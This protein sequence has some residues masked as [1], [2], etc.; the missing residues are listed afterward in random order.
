[1]PHC[2]VRTP[3]LWATAHPCPVPHIR[4]C[5]AEAMP[6]EERSC[7]K[8]ELKEAADETTPL[9][10]RGRTVGTENGDGERG[11]SSP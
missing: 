6:Q 9:I 1:M 2:G 5:R 7:P 10:A 3:H 4:T 8:E 11:I